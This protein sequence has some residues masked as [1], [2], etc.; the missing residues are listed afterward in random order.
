VQHAGEV[1]RR[2][3]EQRRGEIGDVRRAADLVCVEDDVVAGRKGFLGAGL[4]VQERRANDEAVDEALGLELR[5]PVGG[6]G[7]WFVVLAVR[8]MLAV[9]DEVGGEMD[10]P[11]AGAVGG[12][13][14]V[15]RA[16]DDHVRV[17]LD[18]CRVDD[19]VHLDELERLA[20]V[21]GERVA[22]RRRCPQLGR[23]DV[24][25]RVDGL[26]ADLGAEVPGAA[27][28]EDPHSRTMVTGPSFTSSSSMCAPKTPRS[29]GTPSASSSA[30]N[31]SYSGSASS[32]AA[33]AVKLGRLP[34]AVSSF[35]PT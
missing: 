17:G 21:D 27:G 23:D 12:G 2:E 28:D 22:E 26:P 3:L 14:H 32:G 10:E 35:Y 11:G 8:R 19:D 34:F 15:A 29:T 1:E 25:A 7:G 30:Q 18:V 16:A 9:E 5:L 20:Q 13:G 33:A 31:R 24:V 4:A 6:H